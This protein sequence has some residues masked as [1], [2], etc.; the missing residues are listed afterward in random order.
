MEPVYIRLRLDHDATL[1]KTL[2]WSNSLNP[3]DRTELPI[4][5]PMSFE[6]STLVD[7]IAAPAETVSIVRWKAGEN[8]IWIRIQFPSGQ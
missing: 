6:E 4:F 7:A 3:I 2:V 1:C 5:L 8:E